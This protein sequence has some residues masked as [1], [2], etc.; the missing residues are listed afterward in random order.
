MTVKDIVEHYMQFRPD[1]VVGEWLFAKEVMIKAQFVG[2]LI[3]DIESNPACGCEVQDRCL[4]MY[5]CSV[6]NASHVNPD[7]VDEERS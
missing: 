7:Y 3:A 6:H 5:D 1:A 2:E 4:L